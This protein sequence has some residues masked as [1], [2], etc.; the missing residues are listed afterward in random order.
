MNALGPSGVMHL[1]TP[2]SMSQKSPKCIAQS[3]KFEDVEEMTFSGC[4][5]KRNFGLNFGALKLNQCFG[6]TAP[7]GKGHLFNAKYVPFSTVASPGSNGK[8]STESY[9]L[10]EVIYRAADGGLLDVQHD[11]KALASYEPEYWR[12]L[13]DSRVGRT[14]WPFGS[15]VWSKKEWV[16]P[17]WPHLHHKVGLSR[18]VYLFY[19]HN[20]NRINK[21]IVAKGPKNNSF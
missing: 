7:L 18:Y 15:G 8:A 20:Q 4:L 1:T 11:M 13:F 14:A 17:V 10:D 6:D 9:S 21:L 5:P 16:L 2:L 19:F 3:A 12:A